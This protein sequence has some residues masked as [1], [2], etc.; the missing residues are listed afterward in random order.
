M[1]RALCLQ[2]E[3]GLICGGVNMFGLHNVKGMSVTRTQIAFSITSDFV[4]LTL[5][6][7]GDNVLSEPG[8]AGFLRVSC[9]SLHVRV[10][11]LGTLSRGLLSL[12]VQQVCRLIQPWGQ[13]LCSRIK[14][15]GYSQAHSVR[16]SLLCHEYVQAI[17]ISL[18]QTHPRLG[19]GCGDARS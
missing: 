4:V 7:S 11:Y 6:N 5:G 14:R 1:L 10:H 2:A 18:A 17:Y 15:T 16:S 9:W 3:R 19:T 13:G 12:L 8:S